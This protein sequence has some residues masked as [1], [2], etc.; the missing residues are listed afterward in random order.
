MV[1]AVP[2]QAG[3]NTIEATACMTGTL[4]H[5]DGTTGKRWRISSLAPRSAPTAN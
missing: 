3:S 5:A 4:Y 1:G 2:G